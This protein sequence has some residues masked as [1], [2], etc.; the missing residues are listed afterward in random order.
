MISDDQNIN[1][2]R[3]TG[4]DVRI[5]KKPAGSVFSP[6]EIEKVC[7]LMLIVHTRNY[8][9]P[10]SDMNTAYAD[11]DV[12]Y[13]VN[14]ACTKSVFGRLLKSTFYIN[15]ASLCGYDFCK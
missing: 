11:G 1:K 13:R 8:K 12:S 14:R 9:I 3:P 10:T 4:A 6:Q 15:S 5:V 2:L 7:C